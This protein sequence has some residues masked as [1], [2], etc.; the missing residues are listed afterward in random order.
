VD[1]FWRLLRFIVRS[2]R[3]L[4]I[5]VVGLAVV[6]IGIV[7]IPAP[8]PGWA[9]VFAGLA[10]LATEFTWAEILLDRAKRQAIKAKDLAV[11]SVNGRRRVPTNGAA[12]DAPADATDRVPTN[13]AT[14]DAAAADP[15]PTDGATGPTDATDPAPPTGATGPTEPDRPTTN[16]AAVTEVSGLRTTGHRDRRSRLAEGCHGD[17]RPGADERRRATDSS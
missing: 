13:G 6:A 10:I 3:R 2:T 8:G 7:M 15:A 16:G 9:V 14:V 4:A 11:R 1:G 5:L 17:H 12:V